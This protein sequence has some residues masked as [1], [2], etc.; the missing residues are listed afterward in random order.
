MAIFHCEQK[1]DHPRRVLINEI[2]KQLEVFANEQKI[3]FVDIG[4]KIPDADGTFLSG[5]TFDFC[6]PTEKGYQIWADGI[7]S[8]IS[9][10]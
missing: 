3:T 4:P 7:R 9:E 10:P 1:N 6:H 5:M 2:N 8:I